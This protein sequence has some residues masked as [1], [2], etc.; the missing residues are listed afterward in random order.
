L[1][2]IIIS[3]EVSKFLERAADEFRG[4]KSIVNGFRNLLENS[5]NKSSSSSN[6]TDVPGK[7]QIL[8]LYLLTILVS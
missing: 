1:T 6:E 3:L 4:Y 7:I 2:Y 5:S 8:L